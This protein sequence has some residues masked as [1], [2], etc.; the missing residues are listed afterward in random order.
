MPGSAGMCLH[1]GKLFCFACRVEEQ[2]DL[3]TNIEMHLLAEL[4]ALLAIDAP[5]LSDELKLSSCAWN[6]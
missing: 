4:L 2:I 3:I 6:L 1:G 5:S